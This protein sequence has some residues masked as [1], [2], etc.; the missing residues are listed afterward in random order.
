MRDAQK[1][2]RGQVWYLEKTSTYSGRTSIQEGSRPVLIVSNDTNNFESPTLNVVSITTENKPPLPI[3]VTYQARLHG[4]E[5]AKMQ[6]QTILCNQHFTIDKAELEKSGSYYMYQL[7]EET[8]NKVSAAI[9]IQFAIEMQLPDVHS[10]CKMLEKVAEQRIAETQKKN[11]INYEEVA[12]N[13]A[14]TVQDLLD[15]KEPTEKPAVHYEQNTVEETVDV[16]EEVVDEVQEDKV[17]AVSED[18]SQKLC[19]PKEDDVPQVV[20]TPVKEEKTSSQVDKFN[21][22][23]GRATQTK[24]VAEPQKDAEPKVTTKKTP[25]KRENTWTKEFM[26]QYL[27]DYKTMSPQEI[28]DKYKLSSKKTA[29]Q[30]RYLFQNKLGIH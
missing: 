22:R 14:S 23:F 1:F 12:L 18:A 28:V 5:G 11:Q 9:A 30:Y 27:E 4:R 21:A 2:R 15:Y 24:P 26:A 16:E 17:E 25:T 19:Y 7:S 3:N 10:F 13:I 8:M 29:Y 6:R 20:S